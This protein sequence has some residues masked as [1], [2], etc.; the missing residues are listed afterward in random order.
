MK[1]RKLDKLKFE[2]VIISKFG[3]SQIKGG[4]GDLTLNKC[5]TVYPC[6][7]GCPG[8]SRV[9]TMICHTNPPLTD[10]VA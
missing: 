5:D 1:S 8:H 4:Q 7:G 2:K 9:C 3:Q 10:T 6:T